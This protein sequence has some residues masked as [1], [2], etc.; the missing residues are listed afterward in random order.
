MYRGA[1]YRTRRQR[2]PRP[3]AQQRGAEDVPALGVGLVLDHHAQPSEASFGG[4]RAPAVVREAREHRHMVSL[5]LSPD[6]FSFTMITACSAAGRDVSRRLLNGPALG[7]HFIVRGAK[8][9][10]ALGRSSAVPKMSPPL[11]LT[12]C[13]ITMRSLRR[14]PLADFAHLQWSEKRVSTAT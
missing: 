5:C 8:D 9:V 2:C 6:W 7:V 3:W 1:F 13:W 4:F 10:P 14:H 11:A 12:L